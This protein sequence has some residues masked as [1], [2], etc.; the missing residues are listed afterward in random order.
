MPDLF[1]GIVHLPLLECGPHKL[2]GRWQHVLLPVEEQF[3]S[4]FLLILLDR[5]LW[6]AIEVG[7]HRLH[8][9]DVDVGI[10]TTRCRIEQLLF[11]PRFAALYLRA[12][13]F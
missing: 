2:P 1:E 5:W 3:Q 8:I 11:S 9:V 13:R 6:Q 4:C 7:A 10:E 12:W